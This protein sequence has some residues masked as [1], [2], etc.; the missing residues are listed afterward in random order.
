VTTIPRLR[1]IAWVVLKRLHLLAC[2]CALLAAVVC[3]GLW[4]LAAGTNYAALVWARDGISIDTEILYGFPRVF[5]TAFGDPE[6]MRREVLRADGGAVF[7]QRLAALE[8]GAELVGDRSVIMVSNGYTLLMYQECDHWPLVRPG[9]PGD[10]E[11]LD[12]KFGLLRYSKWGLDTVVFTSFSVPSWLPV[13]VLAPY[14]LLRFALW[15]RARW[16]RVRRQRRGACL[17]CGYDLTGNV[18]GTCPECGRVVDAAKPASRPP[19]AEAP[20]ATA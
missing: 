11:A 15:C 9:R 7:A 17:D 4:G 6:E 20:S 12:W 10:M 5:V 8:A 13:V 16:I 3:G 14:P 1:R 2:I 19:V 18:S